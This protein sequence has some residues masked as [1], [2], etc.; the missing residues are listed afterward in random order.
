[1]NKGTEQKKNNK[2]NN[3]NPARLLNIAQKRQRL[4]IYNC[5]N[6][7]GVHHHPNRYCLGIIAPPCYS[8]IRIEIKLCMYVSKNRDGARKKQMANV[9]KT[10]MFRK[11]TLALKSGRDREK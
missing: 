6:N 7:L 4:T 9:S 10:I 1:M 11:Q 3:K 8:K 2:M 5:P